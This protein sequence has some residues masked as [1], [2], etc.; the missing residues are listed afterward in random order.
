VTLSKWQRWYV[1]LGFYVICSADFGVLAENRNKLFGYDSFHFKSDAMADTLMKGDYVVSDT[2]TYHVRTPQRGEV[3]VFR[4]PDPPVKVIRRVIGLPGDTV[5]MKD[6]AIYVNGKHLDE[7]YVRPEDNQ[8]TSQVNT[9]YQVP[10]G[11]YFVLGDN[12]DHASDGRLWGA[13]PKENVY[14]GIG[15]IWFSYNQAS[16][17]R[18]DRIGK[19]VE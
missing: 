12:R 2:W 4:F 1:Y 13:I 18:T 9:E 6:G 16:G 15:F 17:L 11:E 10:L 14:G 19:V 3:I 8:R 7:P 5:V